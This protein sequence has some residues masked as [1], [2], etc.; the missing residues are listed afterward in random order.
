VLIITDYNKNRNQTGSY[1]YTPRFLP[2][3]IGRLVV[4]YLVH[5]RSLVLA[6]DREKRQRKKKGSI[7]T[8]PTH[9]PKPRPTDDHYFF[10]IPG[11]KHTQER[12]QV[13][14]IIFE[15]SEGA[16]EGVCLTTQKYHHIAIGITKKHLPSQASAE[17]L[18]QATA[19]LQNV[20]TTQAGHHPLINKH[21]YARDRAIPYADFRDK[22]DI[23]QRASHLWHNFI[24]QPVLQVSQPRA[25]SS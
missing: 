18:A 16:F 14:R 1:N 11:Q 21:I 4:L 15:L 10:V 12:G 22:L 3:Q 7:P 8:L 5:V 13:S 20:F 6:L 9:P 2:P 19:L 24:L 17:D 25:T 23:F